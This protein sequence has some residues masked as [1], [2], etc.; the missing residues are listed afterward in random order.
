MINFIQLYDFFNLCLNKS[1]LKKRTY[2]SEGNIKTLQKEVK[3]L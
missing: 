2:K 3:E 1:Y